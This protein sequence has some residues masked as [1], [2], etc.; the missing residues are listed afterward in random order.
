MVVWWQ[1]Q[2]LPRGGRG[3]GRG[4]DEGERGAE[5]VQRLRHLLQARS[6]PPHLGLVGGG[7]MIIFIAQRDF[8]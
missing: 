8:K 5:P 6:A 7:I 4:G 1:H 3:V 2:A